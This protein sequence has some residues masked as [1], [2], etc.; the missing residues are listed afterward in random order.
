MYCM[1]L[2]FIRIFAIPI[3]GLNI[4]HVKKKFYKSV[5]NNKTKRLTYKFRKKV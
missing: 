1:V 5:T 4:V 3:T 2:F